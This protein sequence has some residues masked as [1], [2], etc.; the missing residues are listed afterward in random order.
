MSTRDSR[1]GQKQQKQ[2]LEAAEDHFK[3][4]CDIF[5][6]E[7]ARLRQERKILRKYTKCLLPSLKKSISILSGR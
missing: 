6:R 4:V 1:K 5:Q 3:E 2:G 7:A